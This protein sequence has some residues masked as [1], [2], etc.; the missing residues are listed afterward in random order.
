MGDWNQVLLS[1]V[2]VGGIVIKRQQASKFWRTLDSCNLIDMDYSGSNFI[3]LN[4]KSSGR[5]I[6]ERLDCCFYNS[7]WLHLFPGAFVSHL[8]RMFSDHCPILLKLVSDHAV[9]E[10]VPHAFTLV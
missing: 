9:T 10:V 3:W 8:L 4:N 6:M 5:L 1:F 2:K 7:Q